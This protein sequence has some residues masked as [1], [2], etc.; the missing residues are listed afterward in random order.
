VI[1]VTKATRP[2]Q[3]MITVQLCCKSS[4]S[5]VDC[6]DRQDMTVAVVAAETVTEIGFV[7]VPSQHGRTVPPSVLLTHWRAFIIR[8]LSA[9]NAVL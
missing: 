3:L 8:K 7:P 6:N 4:F 1:P 9:L 5:L 2:S